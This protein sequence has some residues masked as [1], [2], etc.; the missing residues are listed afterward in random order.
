MFTD[1]EITLR[2]ALTRLLASDPDTAACSDDDLRQAVTDMHAPAFVS[3]QAAAMLQARQA[4][5]TP[6]GLVPGTVNE[7]AARADPV[8]A[9]QP[10]PAQLD[11]VVEANRAMLHHRSQLGIN[12]YGVTLAQSGL[13]R[14]ALL[15]HALEEALDLANYLQA[16]LQRHDKEAAEPGK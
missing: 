14:R 12:K 3:E 2:A 6:G 4:L 1:H 5:L 7:P 11:P 10:A 13:S 15:V 9:S 8:D 16:E